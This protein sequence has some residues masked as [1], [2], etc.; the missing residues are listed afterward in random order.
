MIDKNHAILIDFGMTD[1][2]V[3]SE[4]QHFEAGIE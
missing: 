3:D 4:G 1:K 2:Y